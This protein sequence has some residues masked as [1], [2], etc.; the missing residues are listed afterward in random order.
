MRA[1]TSHDD[2]HN[3][4]VPV[5]LSSQ[6]GQPILADGIIFTILFYLLQFE[7]ALAQLELFA[8]I[9]SASSSSSSKSCGSDVRAWPGFEAFEL[10]RAW[11]LKNLKPGP[12]PNF[13]P[14]SDLTWLGALNI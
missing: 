5:G 13:G 1:F 12:R 11:A 3:D 7:L 4:A 6:K 14:D 2:R 9:N 8:W 10:P